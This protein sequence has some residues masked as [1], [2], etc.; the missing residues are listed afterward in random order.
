MNFGVFVLSGILVTAPFCGLNSVGVAAEWESTL[1]AAKREGEGS[2]ITDVTA[3]MRDAL[4]LEF[5]RKYGMSVE[6]F[7]SNGGEVALR[8]AAD[9]TAVQLVGDI[10]MD[11]SAV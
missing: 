6:L 10:E 9:R 5:Q 7:G 8:V 4:M 3:T 1:A 11:G 2:V